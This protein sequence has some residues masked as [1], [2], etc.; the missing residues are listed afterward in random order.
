MIP[1]LFLQR[2]LAQWVVDH[3]KVFIALIA[4]YVISPLDLLP[5][6]ILGPAG[7]IDDILMVAGAIW[8]QKWSQRVSGASRAPTRDVIETTRLD[9]P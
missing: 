9:H 5:E 1:K 4:I 3:P 7:Y 8:L 2:S 6:G